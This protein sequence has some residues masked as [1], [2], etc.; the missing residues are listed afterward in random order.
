MIKL[1]QNCISVLLTIGE[2]YGK[3]LIKRTKY[4]IKG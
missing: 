1:V 3:S 2:D 4:E